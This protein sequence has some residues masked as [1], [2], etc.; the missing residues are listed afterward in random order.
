MHVDTFIN[1]SWIKA[2]LD[3]GSDVSLIVQSAFH[4]AKLKYDDHF[5]PISLSGLAQRVTMTLGSCTTKIGLEN[6]DYTVKLFR[7]V[8]SKKKLYWAKIY[9]RQTQWL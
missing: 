4:S 8:L 5:N 9:S 7:M 3:T 1:G 6:S 2:L